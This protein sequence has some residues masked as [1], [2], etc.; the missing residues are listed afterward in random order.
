MTY[1][2]LGPKG[3]SHI[4]KNKEA[5]EASNPSIRHEDAEADHHQVPEDIKDGEDEESVLEGLPA[6]AAGLHQAAAHRCAWERTTSKL[7]VLQSWLTKY[8]TRWLK[9]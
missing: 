9:N 1:P 5:V 7:S 8:A 2:L 6:T 4:R 3:E